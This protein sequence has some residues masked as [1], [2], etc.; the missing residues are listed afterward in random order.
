[1]R[2]IRRMVPPQPVAH[3]VQH[4]RAVKRRLGQDPE[5]QYLYLGQRQAGGFFFI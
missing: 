1:M 5:Q 2:D 3:E 4:Q